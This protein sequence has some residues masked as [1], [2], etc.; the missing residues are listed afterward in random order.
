M[1][2]F[3]KFIM[4]SHHLRQN[5]CYTLFDTHFI[6][7]VFRFHIFQAKLHALFDDA[8]AEGVIQVDASN[9]FNSINKNTV[10]SVEV[11]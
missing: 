1:N 7:R 8:D 10:E 6:R 4:I 9:S 2:I 5:L 3:T 11:I